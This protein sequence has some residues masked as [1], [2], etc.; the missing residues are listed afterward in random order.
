MLALEALPKRA[1]VVA[2]EFEIASLSV[3]RSGAYGIGL[4]GPDTDAGDEGGDHA[5]FELR[6]DSYAG[7]VIRH[8][9]LAE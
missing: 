8:E 1:C 3:L 4:A 6:F 2:H 9:P 5:G 7:D